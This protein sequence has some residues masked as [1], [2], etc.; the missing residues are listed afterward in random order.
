MKIFWA[1]QSD[2]DQVTGRFFVRDALRA[3]VKQLK[4]PEDI[5]DPIERE[6]KANLAV[7][8]DRKDVTGSPDLAK[9]IF[10]KIARS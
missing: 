3:A 4:Q 9:V 2:T 1:W 5:E 8:H 10:E 7:D 6:N